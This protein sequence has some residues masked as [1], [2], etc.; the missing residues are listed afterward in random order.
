[1]SGLGKDI[2]G[3]L[4]VTES[5]SE[6]RDMETSQGL[7]NTAKEQSIA[8]Q[9]CYLLDSCKDLVDISFNKTACS[10]GGKPCPERAPRKKRRC[11]LLTEQ[12]RKYELQPFRQSGLSNAI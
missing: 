2:H 9:V 6:V 5:E 7:E 12:L 3:C 11:E 8:R 4:D 1:M 10:F